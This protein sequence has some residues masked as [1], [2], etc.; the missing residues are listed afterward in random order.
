[1]FLLR[2]DTATSPHGMGVTKCSS[3]ATLQ[4]SLLP[5]G[6]DGYKGFLPFFSKLLFSF[7]HRI[8][9]LLL[10]QLFSHLNPT[11]VHSSKLTITL[12]QSSHT[13]V[14]SHQEFTTTSII[15]LHPNQND[16]LG[17]PPRSLGCSCIGASME[18]VS[19]FNPMLS[20][21]FLLITLSNS[22]T[23]VFTC[24]ANSP[25]GAYCA[26]N[27]GKSNIIIRCED[28]VGHPGNCNDNLSGTFPIGLS[29]SPCYQTSETAGD[30]A[31]SK[32]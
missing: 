11:V 10:V 19:T 1:M 30:A 23:G 9:F 24:P 26:G 27:D 3:L 12:V 2:I 13:F 6:F 25:N 31:C 21:I 32:K 17:R 22:T 5:F 18:L 7:P 14:Q 28:G 29:Y 8:I 20:S 4:Q 16:L 15:N